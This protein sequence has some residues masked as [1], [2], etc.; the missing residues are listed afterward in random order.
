[1]SDYTAC[2]ATELAARRHCARIQSRS[3]PARGGGLGRRGGR[4][5]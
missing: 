4:P 2:D 5:E 1:M 3:G